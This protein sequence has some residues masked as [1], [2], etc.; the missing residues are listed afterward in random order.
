MINH[1]RI[2]KKTHLQRPLDGN[3]E[4]AICGMLTHGRLYR[5]AL[6]ELEE[7]FGNEETVAGAYLK[8]IFDN[9]AQLRSFHNTL[10][11]A[12]ESLSYE[13]DLAAT[14]NLRRAVQKLPETVK[15][16]WGEKRVETLPKKTTLADLDVWLRERV[17]AKSTIS[18]Q[19]LRNNG[20]KRVT[21]RP[22]LG[23]LRIDDFFC[24]DDF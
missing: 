18:D 5:E 16:R 24:D 12:L 13:H 21:T 19:A 4:K 1:W 11:V 15:T 9:F 6:K 14:Y 23:S 10:H 2:H 17:R 20:P 22:S 7:H 3:A 8:T